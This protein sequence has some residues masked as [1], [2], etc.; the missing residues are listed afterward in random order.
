M[1]ERQYVNAIARKVKCSNKKK[2]EIKK[3]LL[4]DI[5]VRTGQGEELQ[6]IMSQMGTVKEIADC[7]NSG[8]NGSGETEDIKGLGAA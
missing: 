2:Q 8:G 6:E 7:F 3:Q 1:N 5:A 4:A